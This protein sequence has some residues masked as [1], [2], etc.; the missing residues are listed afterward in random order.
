MIYRTTSAG[1]AR[2]LQHCASNADKFLTFVKAGTLKCL[3]STLTRTNAEYKKV[4]YE[5]HAFVGLV[6]NLAEGKPVGLSPSDSK[7]TGFRLELRP[8]FSLES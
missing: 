1:Q 6:V 7:R 3:T 5:A 8:H 4:P 2:C